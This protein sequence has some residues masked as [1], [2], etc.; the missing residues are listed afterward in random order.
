MA[1]SV[2]GGVLLLGWLGKGLIGVL[3][4]NQRENMKSF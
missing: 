4:K 1:G 2:D 3:E